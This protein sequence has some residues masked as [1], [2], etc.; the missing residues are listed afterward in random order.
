[1]G[2]GD[3]DRASAALERASRER[4]NMLLFVNTHPVFDS[5]RGDPRFASVVRGARLE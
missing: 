2:F 4:S 3:R 1:V 5:P